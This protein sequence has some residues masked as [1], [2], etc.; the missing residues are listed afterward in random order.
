MLE[1]VEREILDALEMGRDS[2][3]EALA[4]IDEQLAIRKPR[5]GSWSILE[6][7]EHLALSEQFLV[8]RLTSASRSDCSHENGRREAMI[9][10]RGLDHTRPVESPEAVRPG[11]HFLPGGSAFISPLRSRGA[12]HG[13]PSLSPKNENRLLPVTE[14]QK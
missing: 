6:C 3:G 13:H 5:P 10:D 8:S 1:S 4:G 2:L 12:P 7:V 14:N 11:T 9:A